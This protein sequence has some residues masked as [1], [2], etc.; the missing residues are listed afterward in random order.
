MLIECLIEREGPTA[1]TLGSFTYL[2]R[3][4]DH[5]HKVCPVNSREHREYLMG[6]KDF[7]PYTPPEFPQDRKPKREKAPKQPEWRA[8]CRQPHSS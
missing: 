6:L 3:E 1:M 8:R 2:F 4:N 7:R 5:G